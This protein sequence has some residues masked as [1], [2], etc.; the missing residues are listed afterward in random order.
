[1]KELRDCPFEYYNI[2]KLKII[3]E[4]CENLVKIG[5]ELSELL[6]ELLRFSPADRPD[7]EQ[8]EASILEIASDNM[9]ILSDNQ[10]RG[11]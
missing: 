11:I 2:V 7:I 1:M 10:Q 4:S 5:H 3:A 9:I 8:I 6:H